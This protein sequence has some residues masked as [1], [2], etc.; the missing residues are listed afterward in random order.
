[1]SRPS[2]TLPGLALLASFALLAACSETR[3]A[4]APGSALPPPAAGTGGGTVRPQAYTAP[5]ASTDR[6]IIGETPLSEGRMADRAAVTAACRTQADRVL[7][8]RDRS[9]IMREDE[10]DSRQGTFGTPGAF[11]APMDQMA[12]RYERDRMADDCVARNTR[13]TPDR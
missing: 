9:E 4:Q 7:V 6:R 10:R 13:G 11:R 8:Q 1:M 3:T 2:H 12:R 5:P